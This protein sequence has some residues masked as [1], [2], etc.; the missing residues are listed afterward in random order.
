MTLS[1]STE[2]IRK[3]QESIKNLSVDF[4]IEEG[5]KV[6][7]EAQ[8]ASSRLGDNPAFDLAGLRT[9]QERFSG[10]TLQRT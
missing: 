10:S 2:E 3:L 5:L 6:L 1:K 9:L 8:E 7:Q 4:P